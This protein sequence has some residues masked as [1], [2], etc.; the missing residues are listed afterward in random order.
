VIA[1]KASGKICKD[2]DGEKS[3]KDVP[4]VEDLPTL[5]DVPDVNVE[6]KP[7]I[8]IVPENFKAIRNPVLHYALLL[9]PWLILLIIVY[10]LANY[11]L[12]PGVIMYISG[13][14]AA[15][16]SLFAF[17]V[18]IKMI[19]E[20]FR[21]LWRREIIV[22][23]YPPDSFQNIADEKGSEIAALKTG[24]LEE[25]F[26]QFMQELQKM[27]NY[28][29]QWAMGTGFSLLVFTWDWSHPIE[30]FIAFIIGL[31]AWRMVIT[32]IYIWKLGNEFRLEPQLGHPDR[33]GGLSPLGNLC[34]WNALIITIPAIHLG[35]WSI[36]RIF[37]EKESSFFEISEEYAPLYLW[38]LSIL[39]VF[40][41][42][43]FFLP[44]LKV[45][46]IMEK[47]RDRKQTRLDQIEHSI[48]QLES[49]LLNEAEK[50]DEKEFERIQKEL[51]M[52]Q[53]VYARNKKLPVWPFNMGIMIKFLVS[54]TIPVLG[55]I[56][57]VISLVKQATG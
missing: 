26:R 1:L 39:V 47:W 11:P 18:L 27:L 46:W 13:M 32:S 8:E 52:L 14:L 21:N 24:R 45:H 40:A 44:L 10:I 4:R 19:P 53:Q 56:S 55:I 57:E 16:L 23:A 20:T 12:I 34:L 2:E 31:M 22:G 48:N 5:E 51:E 49:R 37:T 9:F 41:V 35:G 30:F 29:Y 17:S 7:G 50:L 38:L 28:P 3:V 42:V 54:Q 25:S 33:S 36:L 43:S 15:A 6:G